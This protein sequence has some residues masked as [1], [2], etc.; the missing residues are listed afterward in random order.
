MPAETASAVAG[1]A[2]ALLFGICSIGYSDNF[3]TPFQTAN[4]L[5][6]LLISL[7]VG[8]AISKLPQNS[9]PKEAI[10]NF[11]VACQQVLFIVMVKWLIVILPLGIFWFCGFSLA[12]ELSSGIQ[13]GGLATYFI[14]VVAANLIQ[15]FIVLPAF[16]LIKG[17]N[18]LKVAKGMFPALAVAFFSKSSATVRCLSR[19]RER[20][21]QSSHSSGSIPLCSADLRSQ[22]T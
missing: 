14:V 8:I 10:Y 7:A 2:K 3:L 16:L 19:W 9:K 21:K 20:R 13:L 17:I 18:P 22:S 6:V 4:V 11:V 1:I 15:M 12:Q 5:S